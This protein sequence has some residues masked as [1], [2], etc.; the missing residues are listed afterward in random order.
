[1]ALQYDEMQDS[2]EPRE[3]GTNVRMAGDVQP[4]EPQGSIARVGQDTY[5][6]ET[7]RD[8]VTGSFRTK[9]EAQGLS[10]TRTNK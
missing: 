7:A 9:I 1:M 8:S 10:T 3:L 6:R 4:L 2:G 5:R